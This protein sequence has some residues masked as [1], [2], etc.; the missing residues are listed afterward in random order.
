MKGGVKIYTG[1]I[2]AKALETPGIENVASCSKDELHYL[3]YTGDALAYDIATSFKEMQPSKRPHE[4]YR[5]TYKGFFGQT[6]E[7]RTPQKLQKSKLVDIILSNPDEI[8]E[9][10]SL[11]GHNEV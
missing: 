4:I 5:V 1:M 7:T 11:K 10:C 9:H 2:E 8:I 6:D 3:I